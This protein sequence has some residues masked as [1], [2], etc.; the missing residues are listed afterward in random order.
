MPNRALVFVAVD[1]KDVAAEH[2]GQ[3]SH[4]S[5]LAPGRVSRTPAVVF[6]GGAHRLVAAR[7]SQDVVLHVRAQGGRLGDEREFHA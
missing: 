2:R 5:G 4:R 1:G 7:A 3:T 6:R